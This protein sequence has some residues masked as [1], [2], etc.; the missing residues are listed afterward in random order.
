MGKPGKPTWQETHPRFKPI[1]GGGIKK[2]MPLDKFFSH[3]LYPV[4]ASPKLDGIRCI[5]LNNPVL[6]T[7]ISRPVCR[8]LDDI[9][10]WAIFTELAAYCPPGL[11][12]EIITYSNPELFDRTTHMR[13]FNQIQSDVMS[14]QGV[15]SFKFFVFD[16]HDFDIQYPHLEPYEE[17][18]KKLHK[19]TLHPCVKLVPFKICETREE[20][21]AYEQWCVGQGF[22]GVCWRHRLAQYKYG[23]STLREQHLIK[24]KQF[25]TDEGEV[26]GTYEERQNQNEPERNVLGYMERSSHSANF[27]GK[28]RLGGLTV[29]WRDQEFD[30]GSGF[31]F[32]EREQYWMERDSLVGRIVTFK[33]QAH[34]MKDKPRTPIFVG[35]RDKRDL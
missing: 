7:Q 29:K 18:L 34:G 35:F 33:Y 3:V 23:R 12:G 22:E 5:T 11:D 8:S 20:I 21:E 9:P 15:P 27:V 10:N 17:R 1:L 2:D 26:I 19:L 24:M 16:Y 6:E 25:I 32:A 13:K 14:Q 30:I 28:G 4:I 31:N